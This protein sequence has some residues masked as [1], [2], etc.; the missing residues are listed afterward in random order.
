MYL[1]YL[2]IYSFQQGLRNCSFFNFFH[3]LSSF[4]TIPINVWVRINAFRCVVY[5]V[6]SMKEYRAPDSCYSS[7]YYL[8]SITFVWIF[9]LRS[10]VQVYSDFDECL[11]R[12]HSSHCSLLRIVGKSMNTIVYLYIQIFIVNLRSTEPS[13]YIFVRRTV[14]YT[15]LPNYCPNFSK[16]STS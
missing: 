16:N 8:Q 9:R 4:P 7:R 6:W 15:L 13:K 5:I 14:F 11:S 10:N 1:N 3:R 12:R 2:F